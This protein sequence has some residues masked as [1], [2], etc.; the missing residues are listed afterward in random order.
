MNLRDPNSMN[1]IL[2]I[3][4]RSGVVLS[5]TI[6]AI[7]TALFIANH[8]LDVTS[9]YLV[10]NP[11]VIPHGNFP[12]SL[13][14]IASGLLSLDPSSIIQFG[15]LVL[16]A[17]PVARV[18]LSLFLFAAEKDRMFVYLTATVLAILLFSM[19]ATPLIPLFSG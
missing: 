14:S 5:G 7:G 16:L 10:Y 13:T 11:G 18:A 19:L 3:V 4:L 17:T 6:I 12:V 9:A 2:G 1:S 8:S 15:F